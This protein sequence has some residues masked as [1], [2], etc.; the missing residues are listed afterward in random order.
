MIEDLILNKKYKLTEVDSEVEDASTKQE[1]ACSG[2]KETPIIVQ[3][4]DSGMY[5]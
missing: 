5:I 1:T 3:A 4:V 2:V